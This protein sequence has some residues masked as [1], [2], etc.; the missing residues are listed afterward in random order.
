MPLH[1]ECPTLRLPPLPDVGAG[2]GVMVGERVV[3]GTVGAG[4]GE[5]VGPGGGA[6]K[7]GKRLVRGADL[8]NFLSRNRTHVMGH[9]KSHLQSRS[10]IVD[11]NPRRVHEVCAWVSSRPEIWDGSLSQHCLEWWRTQG[12]CR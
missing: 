8:G 1:G 7:N 11:A 9:D 10:K 3:G 5:S 6:D 2:V 4:D 12:R